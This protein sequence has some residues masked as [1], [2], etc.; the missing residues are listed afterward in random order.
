MEESGLAGSLVLQN[1]PTHPPNAN[2]GW[3]GPTQT[4][5]PMYICPSTTRYDVS[6][7]ELGHIADYNN[8]GH[9]DPG[10]GLGVSDYGGIQGPSKGEINPTTSQPYD[11]N[12]G[13]LL[14][15]K[16]QATIPG[17]HVAPTV[18]PRQ[19]TDGLSKT[20]MVG[21][22]AGRGYN[23][24]KSELRGVW[25]DG[26]NL[27]AVQDVINL[28][29]TV[30]V[31]GV[32]VPK[33]WTEDELYSEHPGGANVLFCDGSVHFLPDSLDR[34]VIMALASRAGGEQIPADQVGL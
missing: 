1:R 30:D 21:E 15:I 10:E 9:W 13:V 31:N 11:Y 27:F 23:W 4:V 26:N 18:G 29:V 6:R 20:M 34:F 19:I 7:N 32:Q 16:D 3:N 22:L 33:Q 24:S 5:L 14:N 12:E 28:N 2:P 25:A 17:I 8:N